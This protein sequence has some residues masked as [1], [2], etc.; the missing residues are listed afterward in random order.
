MTSK[1][2]FARNLA[3]RRT[4]AE[5]TQEELAARAGYHRTE[6]ALL[7]RGQRMPHLETL[8]KLAA[9]LDVRPVDLLE[10]L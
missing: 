1:E 5:I 8:L 9:A 4:A 10:G 3:N 2:Q 7:E 6:I